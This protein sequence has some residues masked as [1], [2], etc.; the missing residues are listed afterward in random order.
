MFNHIE[1][2]PKPLLRPAPKATP[3]AK[4]KA[5][6][7]PHTAPWTEG[8]LRESDWKR[9]PY[10]RKVIKPC[11]AVVDSGCTHSVMPLS[12]CSE[13]KTAAS[14]ESEAGREFTVAHGAKVPDS[15]CRTIDVKTRG[16]Y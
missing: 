4:A 14:R 8:G 12:Y 3:K 9:V 15:G 5:K 7:K 6:A 11:F 16:R 10:K 13:Y 2:S 1:Y